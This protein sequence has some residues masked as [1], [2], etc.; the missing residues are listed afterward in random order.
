MSQASFRFYSSL[1]DFLPAARR[2]WPVTAAFEDGQSIKHLV[3]SLGVP[4]PEVDLLLANGRSV[5]FEYRVQDGDQI[6]AFPLF[7]SLDVSSLSQVRPAPL[8]GP[9]FVLDNHLGRLASYLRILGFDTLYRNDFE[10]SVLV[11]T[12][13]EDG[14]ALL[15]RDQD[16]LKRREV[17]HGYWVR[18]KEPT[19]Q[20]EEV[21]WRF[22][23]AGLAKPFSR[24]PRCNALLEEVPKKEVEDRLEPKTRRYYRHF[25]R[26]AGC[27]QVYWQGSHWER[28]QRW[29]SPLL[30]AGSPGATSSTLPQAH[31]R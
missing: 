30:A 8:P 25:A 5:S 12:A 15:T 28:L 26:C 22:S 27:G 2:D 19:D 21:V 6:S 14:R 4:H 13:V 20:L 29:L 24:C 16:L 18:A 9:R 7:T 23:L 31:G 17:S 1:Q 10:D 3:E 11:R